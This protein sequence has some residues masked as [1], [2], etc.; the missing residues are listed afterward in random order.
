VSAYKLRASLAKH[1]LRFYGTG[2]SA[3]LLSRVKWAS[4][5]KPRPPTFVLLLRGSDEVDE[6]GTRFLANVLRQSC[7]LQGVPLRLYLRWVCVYGLLTARLLARS[8]GVSAAKA[9]C[10]GRTCG[11]CGWV[12]VCVVY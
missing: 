4:Q 7:G 5:L 1:A 2:G 6:G 8:C 3:S 12:R 11:A 10:C 9:C